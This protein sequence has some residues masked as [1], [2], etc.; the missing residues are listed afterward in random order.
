MADEVK[1]RAQGRVHI[2]RSGCRVVQLAIATAVS[3][4][5][6]KAGRWG[7]WPLSYCNCLA[8]CSLPSDDPTIDPTTS[9]QARPARH[10]HCRLTQPL[11]HYGGNDDASKWVCDLL[12]EP[13]REGDALLVTWIIPIVGDLRLLKRCGLDLRPDEVDH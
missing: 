1:A 6:D 9:N 7:T 10:N 2:C 12:C 4:F 3:S 5:L 8:K 13:T 11:I